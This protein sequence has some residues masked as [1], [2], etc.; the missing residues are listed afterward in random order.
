[1]EKTP[2]AKDAVAYMNKYHQPSLLYKRHNKCLYWA[3][4]NNQEVV[5]K[6][7][8]NSREAQNELRALEDLGGCPHIVKLYDWK[9]WDDLTLF[10]L[11]YRRPVSFQ[12]RTAKE[13]AFYAYQLLEALNILHSNGIVHA[14]LKPDNII[15]DSNNAVTIIDFGA[16]VDQLFYSEVR[17]TIGTFPYIAPE[18]LEAQPITSHVDMWSLGVILAEKILGRPLF[19]SVSD[20]EEICK[21]KGLCF[22]DENSVQFDHKDPSTRALLEIVE[23]MLCINPMNRI[24]SEHGRKRLEEVF[25]KPE[26]CSFNHH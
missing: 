5:L 7:V 10:V 19:S 8:S 1:M 14:D 3:T 25:G 2:Y 11:E 26:M 6:F 16:S 9:Q 12:P 23:S 21:G 24:S 13:L 18:V 15:V 20:L 4:D 17:G 22:V